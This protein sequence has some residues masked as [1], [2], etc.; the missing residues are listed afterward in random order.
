MQLLS[1]DL[2]GEVGW[3]ETF[4]NIENWKLNPKLEFVKPMTASQ[5]IWSQAP[6]L[7][8]LLVNRPMVSR[9]ILPY[10]AWINE[11]ILEKLQQQTATADAMS[12][13]VHSTEELSMTAWSSE[14]HLMVIA[15]GCVSLASIVQ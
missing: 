5:Q 7:M 3:G 13:F 2:M 12:K 4:Q 10:G 6:W 9:P 1:Y 15:G 8:N 14:G 11:K